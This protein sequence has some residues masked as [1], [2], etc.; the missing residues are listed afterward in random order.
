M[1]TDT[2][3]QE[4]KIYEP[5]W[6]EDTDLPESVIWEEIIDAPQSV[7]DL[8]AED[9]EA[10]A[11]ATTAID[12]LGDLAY[13]DLVDALHI[14]AGAVETAAIAV[15]AI[16]ADT[17]A[18][19]A[20][21]TVKISDNAIEA[22]KIAAGA[23]TAGKI[24]TDAIVAANIQAGAITSSKIDA[25]A[26]TAGKIAAGAIDGITITGSL[27]RTS[28]S[29]TRVELNASG[30]D[31]RIYNGGT[32]RAYGFESGWIWR[33]SSGNEVA[34]IY[35]DTTTYS[36][37][38]LL[39]TASGNSLGSIYN[40]TGSSGTYAIYNG[41]Q[42]AAYWTQFEMI[43]AY[44]IQPLSSDL[45]LGGDPY[46]WRKLFLD[47]VGYVE[48][49]GGEGNPFPVQ[50]GWSVSKLGTGRYRVNHPLNTIFYSVMI[51]PVASTVKNATVQDR[52]S[53]FFDVRIANL[54]DSLE[55]NDFMFMVIQN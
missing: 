5:E 9:G 51:T 12:G 44:G 15:G 41:S 26:I 50:S 38:S 24:A 29:G 47:S 32:L 42:L 2:A 33:N 40:A 6:F 23:I 31:I 10:L 43:T 25:G 39:I 21:T 27:I 16:T 20:I 54:S 30:N 35:A 55:D 17:I 7:A 8:N 34:T 4:K 46:S 53:D 49:D 3:L 22:A 11:A 13:E 1:A 19:S 36:S 14:S 37:R 45:A 52:D 28:S 48:A 18:A